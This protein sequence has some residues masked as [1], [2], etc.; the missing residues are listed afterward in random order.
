MHWTTPYL[1][2]FWV[3]FQKMGILPKIYPFAKLGIFYITHSNIP[4]ILRKMGIFQNENIMILGIIYI[5]FDIFRK[6]THF[7]K[8]LEIYPFAIYPFFW[9][10]GYISKRK[11]TNKKKPM[12]NSGTSGNILFFKGTLGFSWTL[13][14]IFSLALSL[15]F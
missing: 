6:Y 3:Y 1:V 4:I 12:L 14:L 2:F 13:S 5:F 11:Y 9:K 10:N 15:I 7:W 8:I